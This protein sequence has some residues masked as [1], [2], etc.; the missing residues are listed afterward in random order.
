MRPTETYSSPYMQNSYYGSLGLNSHSPYYSPR[1]VHQNTSPYG[2]SGYSGAYELDQMHERNIN[3]I[4]DERKERLE[5]ESNIENQLY[6]VKRN[7][8]EE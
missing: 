4:K 5:H 7:H 2:Y 1:Y 8:E 3:H 6:S